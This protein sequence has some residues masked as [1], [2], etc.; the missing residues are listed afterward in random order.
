[1][2]YLLHPDL[3]AGP[4]VAGLEDKAACGPAHGPVTH[5]SGASRVGL[6]RP[7][8]PVAMHPRDLGPNSIKKSWL[9]FWLER[10]D[11]HISN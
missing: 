2:F 4:H 9:E 3:I 7:E 8:A 11:I 5:D 1:M 6:C 10:L